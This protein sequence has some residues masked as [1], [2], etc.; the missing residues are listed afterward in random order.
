MNRKRKE[1]QKD[2]LTRIMIGVGLFSLILAFIPGEIRYF[3]P[4]LGSLGI[5]LAIICFFRKKSSKGLAIAGLLLSIFSG[6]IGLYLIGTG[7]IATSWKTITVGNIEYSIPANWKSEQEDDTLILTTNDVQVRLS[8]SEAL[9]E[10]SFAA[11]LQ[12]SMIKGELFRAI[13]QQGLEDGFGLQN[14]SLSEVQDGNAED[15]EAH[16]WNFTANQGEAEV[17]GVVAVVSID[18]KLLMGMLKGKNITEGEYLEVFEH[19]LGSATIVGENEMTASSQSSVATTSSEEATTPASSEE[20]VFIPQDVSDETIESIKTYEDYLTMYQK[21]IDDYYAQYEA[22][23]QGTPLYSS[24]AFESLKQGTEQGME[25]QKRQYGKLKNAPIVGK[26][27]LV[28]FLKNFRDGLKEQVD[29]MSSVLQ[30]LG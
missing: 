16:Y 7:M 6:L 10:N 2:V 11:S 30:G 20:T 26:A 25:Q 24:E 4:I 5:I 23:V 13:L 18:D 3:S 28:T 14:V 12:Q 29:S 19:I 15:K 22:V 9:S 8:S 21:I 27:D 1:S 17:Q